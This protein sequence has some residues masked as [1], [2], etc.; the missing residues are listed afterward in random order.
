MRE[1]ARAERLGPRS[2]RDGPGHELGW[3]TNDLARRHGVARVGGQ[4][5][6]DTDDAGGRP[7]RPDGRRDTARESAAAH[8]HEDDREVRKVLDQF[9]PDGALARD[10]PIVVV[11]RDD[12]QPPL[13][14]DRLGDLLSLV[15]RGPDDDD[16]RTIRGHALALDRRRV[17]R[18]DDD[19][20][21]AE[22]ASG[23]RH[24]LGMIARGIGDDAVRQLV[25]GQ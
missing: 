22:Q 18:H 15:A 13:G 12:R 7:E 4:L 11:G 14:G 1:G 10:D 19:S 17:R 23:T 25:G 5:G 6:F 21:R 16:L 9:E 20:R 2:V 24:A 3:P 8:R